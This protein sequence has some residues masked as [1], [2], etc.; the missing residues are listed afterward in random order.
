MFASAKLSS[1]A[2][3]GLFAAG[4]GSDP[5]PEPSTAADAVAAPETTADTADSDGDGDSETSAP[6]GID[7]RFRK[8]CNLPDAR[9]NFDSSSVGAGAKKM[10]DAIATCF[11][12]GPGKGKGLN[13]VGH[14][15]PRGETEYNFAL[16]QQRA[17]A[18]AGYLT[19]AGIADDRIETSSRG[20]TEATGTD[21]SGWSR[22]RKVEILL[23]E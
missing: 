3:L 7:E 15:D 22:D 10:L 17:G 19:N 4:C 1:L 23:A 8:M 18:V 13:I 5:V 9:F 16:G 6:V 21:A 11:V 2:V 14:A 20:E 12:D